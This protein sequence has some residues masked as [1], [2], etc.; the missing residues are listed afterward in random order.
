MGIGSFLFS[1]PHFLTEKLLNDD[2]LEEWE[3]HILCLKNGTNIIKIEESS[4]SNYL[5]AFV[6]GRILHGIGAAPI[7]SLG[8]ILFP[9][10]IKCLILYI[11]P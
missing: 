1:L 10:P 4:L 9:V 2:T 11:W 7:L 6:F 3:Q 5:I 8:K